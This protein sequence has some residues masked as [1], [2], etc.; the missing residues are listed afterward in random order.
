M[1]RC[2]TISQEGFTLLPYSG[3]VDDALG[4]ST[5]RPEA[6]V[7]LGFGHFG[8]RPHFAKQRTGQFAAK[9]FLKSCYVGVPLAETWSLQATAFVLVTLIV[10]IL[11]NSNRQFHKIGEIS[12]DVDEI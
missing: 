4:S 5:V 2:K 6:V 3:R 12:L 10:G 8:Q 11:M 9:Q 1:K 7:V